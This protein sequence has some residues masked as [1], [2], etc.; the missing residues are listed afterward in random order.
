MADNQN[1]ESNV[2][3]SLPPLLDQAEIDAALKALNARAT[4]QSKRLTSL[5]HPPEYSI[6]PRTR[7]PVDLGILTQAE[8]DRALNKRTDAAEF[9]RED[10]R[11]QSEAVDQ[12][13]IDTLLALADAEPTNFVAAEA[14]LRRIDQVEIDTKRTSRAGTT[15]EPVEFPAD[16]TELQSEDELDALLLPPAAE[17]LSETDLDAV[18]A[19]SVETSTQENAA[20]VSLGQSEL[21][22]LLAAHPMV[23]EDAPQPLTLGR[24]SDDVADRAA[25]ESEIA[26]VGRENLA[27]AVPNP[28]AAD[29]PLG[30]DLIDSLLAQAAQA[31]ATTAPP[32]KDA[33]GT[34]RGVDVSRGETMAVELSDDDFADMGMPGRQTPALEGETPDELGEAAVEGESPVIERRLKRGA[35][36][37]AKLVASLAASL[38][39]GVGALVFFWPGSDADVDVSPMAADASPVNLEDAIIIAK[40]FMGKGDYVSAMRQLGSAIRSAEHSPLLDEAR[41]L[42]VESGYRSLPPI[43]RD[44]DTETVLKNIEDVVAL[45]PA[46]ARNPEALGWKAELY[47]RTG[48]PTTARDT[49]ARIL[50]N[51]PATPNADSILLQHARLSLELNFWDEAASS[52]QRIV[53]EFPDSPH[54]SNAQMMLAKSYEDSGRTAEAEAAYS[55]VAAARAD[56]RIGAEAALGL[57]RIAKKAGDLPRAIQA[58]ES[59]LQSAT[60]VDGN[61]GVYIE[62]AKA[63]RA[64]GKPV[65]SV[66]VARELLGFFP[67]S[68]HVPEAVV[69]LTRGLEAT[70]DRGQALELAE[71]AAKRFDTNADV[72]RNRALMLSSAGDTRGAAEAMVKADELGANDPVLVLDAGKI[73]LEFQ[74]NDKAEILFKRVL[75]AFPQTPQSAEASVELAR[76]EY[77]RGE[78]AP[79]IDRLAALANSPWA[80]AHG[81][82]IQS[83]L[84]DI[85]GD[86]GLTRRATA[87]YEKVASLSNDPELLAHAAT[88]LLNNGALGSALPVIRK[89][90]ATRLSSKSGFDLLMAQGRALLDVDAEQA[91]TKMQQ[92]FESYP[93]ERTPQDFEFLV[94]ACLDTGKTARARVLITDFD[95]FVQTHPEERQRLQRTAALWGDAL[96]NSGDYRAALDAYALAAIPATAAT[97]VAAI[98]DAGEAEEAAPSPDMVWAKFQRANTMLKLDDYWNSVPILEELAASDSA[99]A[100][101]ARIK[102]EYARLEQRLRKQVAPTAGG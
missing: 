48:S 39:A 74:E 42:H 3:P 101:D 36:L 23:R 62:L 69:E 64:A 54:K 58:L 86:L 93:V 9:K 71:Q 6:A 55:E 77:K 56:S 70:G 38:I 1:T 12:T 90:D 76:I 52:L 61:D 72:A 33:A 22:A 99:F 24:E 49:Y 89:L 19:A 53:Q 43:P 79:A 82:A 91:L 7:K 27:A 46:Y 98:A 94:R 47:A 84:G 14:A 87:A 97:N 59:R 81:L 51:Y 18:I 13:E 63:Y 44:L 66:R 96:Y 26:N 28:E 4:S 57:A 88:A 41:F 80:E 37:P 25:Q 5:T 65:E 15:T 40:E 31:A 78:L 45:N 8:I 60:T 95:S 30:K 32:A 17:R 29:Q 73:Y 68:A 67:E 16:A 34:A 21:D 35:K 100:D 11:A 92:A 85:Y 102:A 50:G 83:A 2:T 20:A 10:A 75:D